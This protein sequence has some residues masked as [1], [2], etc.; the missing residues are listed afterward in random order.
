MLNLACPLAAPQAMNESPSSKHYEPVQQQQQQQHQQD[1]RN[2]HS[3][4]FSSSSDDDDDDDDFHHIGI[5][6]NND[7]DDKTAPTSN[8]QLRHEI[9][10]LSFDLEDE[11]DDDEDETTLQRY[12][13]LPKTRMTPIPKNSFSITTLWQMYL[14]ARIEGRRQRAS[15][16]LENDVN[17]WIICVCSWCDLR[18]NRGLL[19]FLTLIVAWIGVLL[20]ASVNTKLSVSFGIGLILRCCWRPTYWILWGRNQHR[21]RQEQQMA[22]YDELNGKLSQPIG[23]N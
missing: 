6:N 22:M 19:L 18:E 20:F 14:D 13:Y 4:S 12:Q 11:E 5:E 16:L 23:S 15:Q 21:L 2:D 9:H 17:P 8:I 10:H 7:S 3:H 1:F